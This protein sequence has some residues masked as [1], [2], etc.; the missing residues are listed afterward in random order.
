MT[1]SSSDGMTFSTLDEVSAGWAGGAARSP[2]RNAPRRRRRRNRTPRTAAM[3]AAAIRTGHRV[4]VQGQA[5][6][7][8]GG[9]VVGYC[10]VLATQRALATSRVRAMSPSAA[11]K[12]KPGWWWGRPDLPRRPRNPDGDH[13]DRHHQPH[14]HRRNHPAYRPPP[15][16]NQPPNRSRSTSVLTVDPAA[17]AGRGI[18]RRWRRGEILRVGPP[19]GRCTQVLHAWPFTAAGITAPSPAP[20]LGR[21]VG[22]TTAAGRGREPW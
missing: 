15:H 1:F 13:R 6:P 5:G 20:G 11:S 3:V 10:R 17:G 2:P 8:S 12:A 22:P 7:S 4:S 18:T 14:Q 19:A 16:H 9:L 21:S